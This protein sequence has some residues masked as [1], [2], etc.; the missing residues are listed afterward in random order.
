MHTAPDV[1]AMPVVCL[2]GFSLLSAMRVG[3]KMNCLGFG[4]GV[5]G[6]RSQRDQWKEA[7][8]A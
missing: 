1:S 4:F 2:D 3:T 8:R 7:Y 6:Q 5:K